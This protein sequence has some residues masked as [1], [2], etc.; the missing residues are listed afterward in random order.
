MVTT[1]FKLKSKETSINLIKLRKN[2]S[3]A[4]IASDLKTAEA[5]PKDKY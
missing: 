2:L 3:S 5:Y 1:Q 4:E